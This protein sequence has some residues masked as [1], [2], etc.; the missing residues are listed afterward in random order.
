M[1]EGWERAR[2]GHGGKGYVDF[3]MEQ[4]STGHGI[5]EKHMDGCGRQDQGKE[6]GKGKRVRG[7]DVLSTF[8]KLQQ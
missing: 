3:R 8:P 4:G 2:D 1:G 6:K 7:V 5:Q